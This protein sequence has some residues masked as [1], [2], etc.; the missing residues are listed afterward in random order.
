M[1]IETEERKTDLIE[2]VAQS[3][4][5]DGDGAERFVRLLYADVA[6]GDLVGD[7][8]ENLRGAA[9]GLWRFLAERTPGQPSVRVFTPA[10]GTHGWSSPHTVVE[11]VTD[12]MP[13]LV[14]SV[15]GY[16]NGA[17]AEVHLVIHPILSVDRDERGRLRRLA[18]R[19]EDGTRESCMHLRIGAQ[20]RERHATLMEGVLRVLCDVRVAVGDWAALRERCKEIA[21]RVEASPGKRPADEVKEVS[22]FLRWLEANHFTF[23][24]FREIRIETDR[25][26]VVAGSGLGILRDEKTTVFDGL[27]TGGKPPA[28]IFQPGLLRVTKANRRSTVHR[29][30]HLDAIGIKSLDAEGRVT[31]ESLFVGLFTST[32]YAR[33]AREIPVLKRK[34]DQ[35]LGRSGYSPRSHNYKTLLHLLD[36]YPRD[37]L[38]QITEGELF[39]IALGILR[40]QQRRR[41]AFFP[42]VDPFGRFVSCLVYAPRD[43]YGTGLRV[44]FQE[45]LADALGGKIAAFYTHLSDEPLARLHFIVSITPG[46]PPRVDA[47]EIERRLVEAGRSWGERLREALVRARGEEA[48]LVA[49]RRF[50][51]AFPP[52][53]GDAFDAAECAADVARVEQA[54]R[55]GLAVRLD[56]VKGGGGPG[57][58]DDRGPGSAREVRLKLVAAG[59]ERPLSDVLPLLE[60]MGL[61]VLREQPYRVRPEGTAEPV[62]IRELEM[63]SKDPIDLDAVREPFHEA[64]ALVWKGE[65]ESDGFNGLVLRAGLT[66]RETT[67]LRAY[68]KFLRQ[69][70]VAF[71]QEYMEETLARHPAL[72]GLL[73]RIFL[74][75][76]DPKGADRL[77][78]ASGL[79]GEFV[80]GLDAVTNLDEDRILRAFFVCVEATVRTNYFQRDAQGAPKPYLSFKLDSA[81]LD[82]LSQPRPFREVFVYSPRVEAVHLRGGAV[83]RG[84]IRWSDRREDFRTEVLGLMKAQMVKNA[85]IVPVGSKGGFVVKRPPPEGGARLKEEVVECYRTLV[86]GLL[87][88][89]DNRD[90]DRI[91][92]PPLVVRLDGDDPYLVVAA[93]KGT[94]T[95]SDTAN[96]ISQEYG[97]WLDDAFASGGSAGYDHK[98]MAITARGAWEGV[99]RHFREMGKDIQKEDF[100][101]AGVGDMAGDVFGNGMLLSRRIKLVAAF[102]H[103]HVFL[104]P[105]PDPEKSFVERKR[106][107]DLP[108]STWADYEKKLISKGGG[109]W[110]RT[111]KSIPLSEPARKLLGLSAAAAPP[112]EVIQAILRAPVELLWLGGIGTFVRAS[113]ET[114]AQVGDRASD[115][116]RVTA[117]EIRAKV[118]GEGANLGFTQR[119]RVEYALGG[120][121]LNTDAVDNSAGVDCSDHE[122]NIKILLSDVERSGKL[123]R[124]ARDR[125]LA[126]M[127]EEVAALVLSDNYLQTLTISVTHQLGAHVVDRVGRFLRALEKSGRL[128]R[129]LEHLPDEDT[130]AER[131]RD[132]IGVTRPELAVLLAYAKMELYDELLR[133]ALPDDPSLA[134][135]LRNYFPKAL[136]ERFPDAIRGHRLRREITATVVTNDLV[137][138]AGSMFIHEVR[139]KTGMPAE[140]IARAYLAARDILGMRELWREIEAL[141]NRAPA[142][143]QAAM[144]A[145][146]GRLVERTT[147]WLLRHAEHPLEIDRL[148]EAYAAGVTELGNALDTTLGE[149]QK[150][151]LESRL[152]ALGGA[153]PGTAARVARLP[154]LAPACDIV[155]LALGSGRPIEAVARAYFGAGARFGFNW[156]RRA[157]AHLTADTA[158]QK[159]AVSALV[160]DLD[161]QQAELTAR[162]LK[163]AQPGEPPEPAIERFADSRRPLVTRTEQLLAELQ[164]TSLLDFTML[165]VASRQLKSMTL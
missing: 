114:D 84:G 44:R 159:L 42:R 162:V 67:I 116:L 113:H 136:R 22:A 103:A 154:F 143:V 96:A 93:D 139:E 101:V 127:T 12:D 36:S 140:E 54:L 37:E 165:A 102:N 45:V 129:A 80:A 151:I 161:G 137:N 18:G 56:R 123:T 134:E 63:T 95:F 98:K 65:L 23:T 163:L 47:T 89:T 62:W 142:A 82:L 8:P 17:E 30:T 60:R 72:A 46:A 15:T 10:Q 158:W 51:G 2:T 79:A 20:P 14:D 148:R 49:Y 24:G 85:V 61:K 100:T 59:A 64:F 126:E 141:D 71:S 74:A 26:H 133:S 57:S 132:K 104:D 146:C 97:F 118:V 147:V 108:V 32:A 86:R 53:Y 121:R 78:R 153:P 76:F 145:E 48:G 66:A 50:A 4:A 28:E 33:S 109:V 38:F 31:G 110:A 52:G 11:I 111:V 106:L 13:F 3:V 117:T 77:E 107:F 29:T 131:L 124:A 150:K 19:R 99:K 9:L 149:D 112:A 88:L 1:T 58:S 130:L 135:E 83:A 138:R 69:A 90:G 25:A 156:M 6:P 105:D 122:V 55:D 39:P 43:N 75:R 115:A 87:D 92:P 119:A 144:L 68:C 91:L 160:D 21:A 27:I 155:R 152:K 164:A 7:A 128:N 40:L 41:I 94:A 125:L 157:A 34:V 5:N 73:V 120:G 35:V 70:R 16:L 81:R